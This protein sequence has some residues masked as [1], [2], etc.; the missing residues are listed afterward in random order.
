MI[1][2]MMQRDAGLSDDELDVLIEK[3]LATRCPRNVYDQA[4]PL[5]QLYF[6]PTV[7]GLEKLPDKPTLF[8]GNHSLFGVDAMIFLLA[9]HH[10]QGRFVRPLADKVF[11]ETPLGDALV[12]HGGVLANPRMCA[13]LME[14]GSDLVVF[15]GGAA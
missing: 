6:K 7:V 1:A 8:V 4:W 5:V 15:P 10:H 11:F 3:A 2:R 9:L 14:A 12:R 13:A